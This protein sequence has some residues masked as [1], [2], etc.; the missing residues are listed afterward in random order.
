MKNT[1]ILIDKSFN[2]EKIKSIPEDSIVI[3]LDII[4][5]F[6]LDTLKIKHEI[7]EDHILKD[8]IK[9]IDDFCFNLTF[10]SLCSDNVYSILKYDEFHL[11]ELFRNE[12]LLFL[13]NIMKYHVGIINI[14]KNSSFNNIICSEFVGNFINN[15][16]VDE[17]ISLSI[18]PNQVKISND[19]FT[20]PISLGKKTINIKIPMSLAQKT[21]KLLHKI[22]TLLYNFKFS[23]KKD[24]DKNFIVLL[25]LSPFA[26]S[27]FFNSL[28]KTENILLIDEFMPPIWNKQNIQ[29]LKNSNVKII[30]LENLLNKKI[31]QT[32]SNDTKKIM[33]MI[34]N[35]L[36]N[37]DF[38][39]IFTFEG[40]SIWPLIQDYFK[41]Q[42]IEKFSNAIRINELTKDFFTKIKIDKI[43][44]LYNAVPKTQMFLHNAEKNKIPY[45]KIPHGYPI[46]S[47]LAKKISIFEK[48]RSQPNIQFSVWGENEVKFEESLGTKKENLFCP[49]YPPYDKFFNQ[50]SEE[51]SEN[52]I[53][54]GTT[55]LQ[56]IWSLSGHDTNTTILHKNSL[57]EI[58]RICNTY[59]NKKPIIKIHPSVNP[60]FNL[61]SELLK[62]KINI[63]IFKT[64]NITELIKKSDVVICLDFSSILFEAMI[65]GK[66]T[67]TYI[68]D[69]TWYATDEI[70]KSK[71]TVPVRNFEEFKDALDNILNDNNFRNNLVHNAKTFVNSKLNNQGNASIILSDF[72]HNMK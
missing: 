13:L 9:K 44:C 33:L 50:K 35:L 60:S 42:C 57:V 71:Y 61:E 36:N 22:S 30:K 32:I 23:E 27:D 18:I 25:D 65:L 72:V 29:I 53:L 28:G 17:K 31:E 62:S 63:P 39:Q 54:I 7:I 46:K 34:K 14:L 48:L 6:N 40:F 68:V 21:A 69:P 37:D 11:G 3:S 1:L 16:D 2:L 41:Q 4:S 24:I 55:F 70:I 19:K 20:T 56:Y 64:Q 52:L 43:I 67:I 66:P 38:V 47:P 12:F 5:H 10:N 8:E 15:L 58:C 26:F 59:Q 51:S 49:G 45:L